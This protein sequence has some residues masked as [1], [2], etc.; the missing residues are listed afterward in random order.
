ME[1]DP[2]GAQFIEHGFISRVINVSGFCELNTPSSSEMLAMVGDVITEELSSFVH[3]M[4]NGQ[5]VLVQ[6]P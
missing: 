4:R 5:F 6:V 2:K 3:K 1:V